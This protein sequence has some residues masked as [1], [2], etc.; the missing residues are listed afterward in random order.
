MIKKL[1]AARRYGL[2]WQTIDN[3]F[4]AYISEGRVDPKARGGIIESI[5]KLT[6]E[7][8]EFL[9]D[10]LDEDCT[11]TLGMIR[12]ALYIHF[13]RLQKK[14]ISPN[15][16]WNFIVK[17]IG[18]TLKRTKPVEERRNT[19]EQLERRKELVVSYMAERGMAY[20]ANCIFVDE[21]GFNANLI[22]GQGW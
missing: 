13:L 4:E 7:H 11:R 16:I 18:F 2:S 21:A 17:R 9:C 10:F 6:K 3:I 5:A 20:K 19:P 14:G 8:E 12:E 1:E 22:R 15:S